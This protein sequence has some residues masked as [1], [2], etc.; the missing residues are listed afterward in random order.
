M[1]ARIRTTPRTGARQGTVKVP[2]NVLHT[3]Y[4]KCLDIIR[5]GEAARVDAKRI[6]G[7]AGSA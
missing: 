7:H 2:P 1:G 5:L 3:F 6:V 4:G